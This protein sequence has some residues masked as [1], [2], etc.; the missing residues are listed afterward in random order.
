MPSMS[1]FV[2]GNLFSKAQDLT[3]GKSL[4]IWFFSSSFSKQNFLASPFPLWKVFWQLSSGRYA[5]LYTATYFTW[6]NYNQ[7]RQ[8]LAFLLMLVVT[9]LTTMQYKYENYLRS[10]STQQK[11]YQ[12]KN[13]LEESQIYRRQDHKCFVKYK[14]PWNISAL[15][16]K[17]Q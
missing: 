2:W 14:Q 11:K 9:A 17:L 10:F 13:K 5:S 6:D 4:P 15:S 1:P 12:K 7:E 16:S 3:T 8:A